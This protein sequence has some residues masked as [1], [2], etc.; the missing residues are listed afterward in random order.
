MTGFPI[1]S[2]LYDKY[3]TF[4]DYYVRLFSI[5]IDIHLIR[6]EDLAAYFYLLDYLR[7]CCYCILCARARIQII[8]ATYRSVAVPLLGML[9]YKIIT[10]W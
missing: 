6:S 7:A 10:I 8:L 3:G 5:K 1:N 2:I 9:I 4:I